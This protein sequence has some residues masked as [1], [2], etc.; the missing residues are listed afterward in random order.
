MRSPPLTLDKTAD[1]AVD[2][3]SLT[4]VCLCIFFNLISKS[5]SG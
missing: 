4:N 2:E 1:L 5:L 3:K